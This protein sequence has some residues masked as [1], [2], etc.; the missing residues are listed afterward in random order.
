MESSE[1]DWN[2]KLAH[3]VGSVGQ[4]PAILILLPISTQNVVPVDILVV[5]KADAA[6]A[7]AR[8]SLL[9]LKHV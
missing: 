6:A 2:I 3:I 9:S 1:I 4:D 7:V 5:A 8:P